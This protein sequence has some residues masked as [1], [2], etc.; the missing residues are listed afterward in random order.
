ME[1]L[2]FSV[3]IGQ[4]S[5]VKLTQF[6]IYEGIPFLLQPTAS[7]N[8]NQQT[9]PSF[10]P[11]KISLDEM[12]ANGE[13]S[14]EIAINHLVKPR[15]LQICREIMQNYLNGD[16]SLP[17]PTEVSIATKYG[18]SV[19][20]MKSLFKRVYGK[21]FYQM[22]MDKRMLQASLLLKS[23]YKAIEVTTLVGYSAKSSIKFN[24]MF[25]KYFGTTPKK[26]Q[27]SFKNS[28]KSSSISNN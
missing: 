13:K 9:T 27:S 2:A 12:S 21:T 23:G 4:E 26:Y 14:E 3:R 15:D 24:K 28:P 25:Q 6:L 10:S 22:Y 18:I 1:T 20:K 17:L 11:K 16:F 19:V 8:S 7:L 5:V